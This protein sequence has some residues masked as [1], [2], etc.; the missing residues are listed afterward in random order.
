MMFMLGT[1]LGSIRLELCLYGTE[2]LLTSEY[3]LSYYPK[4][5][6]SLPPPSIHAFF[7]S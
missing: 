2:K 4:V 7:L 3:S 6:M 5:Y 1:Y